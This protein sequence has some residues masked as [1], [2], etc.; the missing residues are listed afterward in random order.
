MPWLLQGRTGQEEEALCHGFFK[1]GQFRKR[2]PFA[3]ASSK[4]D[5]SGRGSHL[6][7]L[8][9]GRTGQEEEALCRDFFKAGQV[10]ESKCKEATSPETVK[11]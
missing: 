4:Q 2:K 3:V 5:S 10:I 7:W 11:K 9:Q 1:A 6:P 8:L